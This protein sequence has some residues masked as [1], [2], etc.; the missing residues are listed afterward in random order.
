MIQYVA[1]FKRVNTEI[2]S[3]IKIIYIYIDRFVKKNKNNKCIIVCITNIRISIN[4]WIKFIN[5]DE[6][7]IIIIIKIRN[8]V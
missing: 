1:S 3:S 6:I 5:V 8:I 7:I 4:G 2:G